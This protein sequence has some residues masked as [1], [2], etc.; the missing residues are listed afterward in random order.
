MY[1][2]S[3][4]EGK[5]REVKE[6]LRPIEVEQLKKEL[7]EPRS[8]S[9]ETIAEKK[10]VHAAE[11]VGGEVLVEDSGLFIDVLDGFPGVYS[12]YVYDKIGNQ[13]ILRLLEGIDNRNAKFI[14]VV[15]Y[16]KAGSNPVCFLGELKGRVSREIKGEHGFGYD[17]I[18]IPEGYAKTNGE[19]G[20]EIK[21][22]ISHRRKA[23]QLFKEWYLHRK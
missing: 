21:N 16:S 17:P 22:R 12:A 1:F 23:L 3:T 5:F 6:I 9:V 20:L 10:A 8:E 4:N 15:A 14:S 11:L 18:F 7:E 19:L 2:V 13:G